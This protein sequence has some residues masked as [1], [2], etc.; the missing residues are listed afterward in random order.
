M[1]ATERIFAKG[2]RLHRSGRL[3]EAEQLYRQ[4]LSKAPH[5]ADSLHWLGVIGLQ[6]GNLAPAGELISAAVRIRPNDAIYHS[7][8][9]LVYQNQGKLDQAAACFERALALQ[10]HYPEAR[11]NLGVL[12]QRQGQLAA[13]V[14]Q[15]EQAIGLRPGYSDAVRNLAQLHFVLGNNAQQAG[16]PE[17]AVEHYTRA[18]AQDPKFAEAQ[19][20]LG[21]ALRD[22]GELGPAAATYE[23]A[24]ALNPR[25]TPAYQALGV[26]A[27]IED[28]P[29]KA[30]KQ[31]EQ[32]LAIEPALAE[33]HYN[34]AIALMGL[35]RK[36]DAVERFRRALSLKPDYIAAHFNLANALVDLGRPT[37]ASA[38]YEK[39]LALDPTFA[40]A[41]VALGNLHFAAG[42][43]DRALMHFREAQRLEPLRRQAAIKP[44]PDFSALLL[45]APGPVNTPSEYLLS[46]ASFD[47][48]TLM[49][50]PGMRTDVQELRA[51]ADVIV[52]LIAE[53]DGARAE[54]V[55]AAELVD[56]L[57]RPV[58]NHPRDMLCTDRATVAKRLSLLPQCRVARTLRLEP[59]ERLLPDHIELSFPVLARV[60]GTHGGKSLEKCADAA[61][62]AQTLARHPESAHYVSEYLPYQSSDGYFRK[63]RLIFVNETIL[64]YHL[65]VGSHWK[66]HYFSSD[67]AKTPRLRVEE[68]AFLQDPQRVL[69]SVPWAAL[70]AVRTALG[71]DF[72]GIDCG[73]DADGKLVIFEANAT[74][75]VHDE[76]GLFA[77][78]APFI[79]AIKRAFASMLARAAQPGLP[80][81]P[82]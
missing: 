78:K 58:I 36:A 25:L 22:L 47:G 17:V 13:A 49:L 68:E 14:A 2:L 75:L 10:P 80:T 31:F 39:T 42:A 59:H 67:M 57:G 19:F 74:M 4:V 11:N 20:N 15:F 50:L 72:A 23:R 60:T 37:D 30:V 43:A 46:R 16:Q 82:R 55:A 66:M 51:R 69:G 32:A 27:L 5:H 61:A 12:L 18:L 28:L 40:Q 24:L 26:L 62:L 73:I 79:A 6:T 38:H 53:V 34:L 33:A 54:L 44:Q 35:D 7:N 77:Y 65:A 29:E 21:N 76:K 8:L 52:N 3:A 56:A 64:P 81:G 70:E 45:T 1:N 63:Y 41:Q 71:L 48:Y 9:G